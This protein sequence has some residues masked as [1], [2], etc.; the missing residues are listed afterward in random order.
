[1]FSRTKAVVAGLRSASGFA[2]QLRGDEG[3]NNQDSVKGW[4]GRA[5]RERIYVAT[6]PQRYGNMS[7]ADL[8]RDPKAWL[9]LLG[10]S[11]A[12][13]LFGDWIIYLGGGWLM[14]KSVLHPGDL[15]DM[16]AGVVYRAGVLGGR[17]PPCVRPLCCK[18]L[19]AQS[20]VCSRQGR[21]RRGGGR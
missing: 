3:R 10:G 9:Y 1:M 21:A 5:V 14:A 12:S 4:V 18:W 13:Y 15:A 6:T 7:L 20:R 19:L 16:P 11:V 8:F 2:R 17:R